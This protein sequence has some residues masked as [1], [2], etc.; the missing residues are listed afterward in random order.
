MSDRYLVVDDFYPDPD[1]LVRKALGAL[2][3]E[4][5]RGNF[6]EVMTF[7]SY[8]PDSHQ[9]R[10]QQL[11]NEPALRPSSELNGKFRLSQASGAHVK[12]IHFDPGVKNQW[13]GVVYLSKAHPEVEGISFW[14]HRQTGLE[15]VPRSDEERS[16]YGW[17]SNGEMRRFFASD[18][19]DVSQW[20]K[21]QTVPF[22]YNR[23]VL[24]RPWLFHS[25]GE[26]FGDSLSTSRIVQTLFMGS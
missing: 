17:S 10:I 2:D 11:L 20:D 7:E 22:K 19:Q 8:L 4:I 15:E 5:L 6:S 23:L 13:S 26:A 21:T 9:Q 18:G 14:K 12:N 24:F 25:S 1:E 3:S 16:K